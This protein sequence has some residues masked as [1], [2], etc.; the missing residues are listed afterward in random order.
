M[1]DMVN[2]PKHYED[3]C[4]IE[5]IHMMWSFIG[6]KGTI[7]FCLGNAYKY[8]WR[9]K[10]KGK[11]KEDLAKAKWYIDTA[12]WM[13]DDIKS[14]D[15]DGYDNIIPKIGEIQRLHKLYSSVNSAYV[16]KKLDE[17][18]CSYDYEDLKKYW[19]ELYGREEKE[20]EN[21]KDWQKVYDYLNSYPTIDNGYPNDPITSAFKICEKHC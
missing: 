12:Y 14:I 18:D 13:V 17:M 4:S 16:K 21:Q 1:E 3:G 8:L 5:C 9:H 15:P 19:D 10:L 7:L 2:H 11:P 6:V 20:D